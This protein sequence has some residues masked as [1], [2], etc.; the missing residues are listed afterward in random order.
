MSSDEQQGQAF[1]AA[2]AEPVLPTPEDTEA[3]RSYEAFEARAKALHGDPS[4]AA[5]QRDTEVGAAA[6]DSGEA[7]TSATAV[8]AAVTPRAVDELRG[9]AITAAKGLGGLHL[10]T[11]EVAARALGGLV[12]RAGQASGNDRVAGLA[13]GQA[14]L[15]RRAAGRYT[16]LGRRL[17]G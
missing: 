6:V 1:T 8:P 16:S 17:L 11:T 15:L 5:A 10:T 13:R 4:T 9:S 3:A 14:D 12:E 7:D 2:G